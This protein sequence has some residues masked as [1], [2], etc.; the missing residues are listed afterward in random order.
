MSTLS[1]NPANPIDLSA[2]ALQ[3]A[4]ERA[5]RQ[6]VENDRDPPRSPY[7]P[8]EAPRRSAAEPDHDVRADAAPLARAPEGL[9]ERSAWHA[10]D[11]DDAPDSHWPRAAPGGGGPSR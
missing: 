6:S 11:A 1:G 7:A 9:R 8:K 2:Y 4:G 5:E 10:A 3:R